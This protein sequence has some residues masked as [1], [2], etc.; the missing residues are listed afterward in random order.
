MSRTSFYSFSKQINLKKNYL[1]NQFYNYLIWLK[2]D[3]KKVLIFCFED[4][5][6]DCTMYCGYILHF[7]SI[8][9]LIV[10]S[11]WFIPTFIL[12][13]SIMANDAVYFLFYFSLMVSRWLKGACLLILNQ[14]LGFRSYMLLKRDHLSE[15]HWS[16]THLD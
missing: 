5:Q 13:M 12:K 8:I 3:F 4:L 16:I 15:L 1:I 2:N 6:M 10:Q 7:Y 11:Y 9:M 14:I